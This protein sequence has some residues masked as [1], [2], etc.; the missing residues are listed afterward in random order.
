M[1]HRLVDRRHQLAVDRREGR[2][3]DVPGLESPV[4]DHAE[5]VGID[6]LGNGRGF[7]DAARDEAR[8]PVGKLRRGERVGEDEVIQARDTAETIHRDGTEF[9]EGISSMQE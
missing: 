5:S 7:D 8:P 1:L 9:V 4:D 3:G 2:A 6:A